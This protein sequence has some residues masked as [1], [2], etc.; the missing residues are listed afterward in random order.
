MFIQ[1]VRYHGAH[2]CSGGQTSVLTAKLPVPACLHTTAVTTALPLDQ[3]PAPVAVV[4]QVCATYGW[5]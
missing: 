2:S 4:N 3:A 1:K 5:D